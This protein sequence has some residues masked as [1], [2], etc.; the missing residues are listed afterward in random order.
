M[1][2]G[3]YLLIT[4]RSNLGSH[5]MGAE[6]GGVYVDPFEWMYNKQ[7]Y[8]R[9]SLHKLFRNFHPLQ[10][11]NSSWFYKDSNPYCVSPEV[12][13]NRTR[14]KVKRYLMHWKSPAI[15]IVRLR[16]C[17]SGDTASLKNREIYWLNIL[18]VL[19]VLNIYLRMGRLSL[20]KLL[21]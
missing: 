8:F 15:F 20:N 13:A 14:R 17:A 11:N 6:L 2:L 4:F 7:R 16:H 5:T 1:P 21:Q 18:S 19:Y 3:N 9:G 12:V 10:S